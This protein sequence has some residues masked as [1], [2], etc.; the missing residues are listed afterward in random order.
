MGGGVFKFHS[1]ISISWVNCIYTDIE[2]FFD[3]LS[4]T[5]FT[6]WENKLPVKFVLTRFIEF[7][8]RVVISLNRFAE[9][10]LEIKS[11]NHWK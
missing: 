5:G 9:W 1:L 3:R 2:I 7:K 10:T 8:I 4:S 11:H 6:E